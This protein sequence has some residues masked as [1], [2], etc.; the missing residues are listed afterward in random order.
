[1]STAQ[2]D[3]PGRGRRTAATKA[4]PTTVRT[5][6]IQK[7]RLIGAMA[8]R[9]LGRARTTKTPMTEARMPM[10][11]TMSGKSDRWPSALRP[12]E[13]KAV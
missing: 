6:A 2:N 1:M 3:L 10:A 8:L 13:L 9:S 4:A 5:A 11:G 12:M 7:P